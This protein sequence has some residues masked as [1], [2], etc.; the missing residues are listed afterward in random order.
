[1][2]ATAASRLVRERLP[3]RPTGWL[4]VFGAGAP[5]SRLADTKLSCVCRT[6][7]R[8]QGRVYAVALADQ[9]QIHRHEI[10]PH[11]LDHPDRSND[12]SRPNHLMPARPQM[13]QQVK[14]YE[15]FVLHDDNVLPI[16]P[17]QFSCGIVSR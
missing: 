9:A 1:M 17:V 4:A 10:G 16:R 11:P 15:D 7:A 3:G 6:A 5:G 14:T 12:V 8:F 2:A 13:R